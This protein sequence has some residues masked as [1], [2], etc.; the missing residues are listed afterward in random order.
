MPKDP[1]QTSKPG[2]M[3]DPNNIEYEEQVYLTRGL[4][5]KDVKNGV[6]LNLTEAKIIKN[7]FKSDVNFEE[8]FA[9]YYDGYADYIE[10]SINKLNELSSN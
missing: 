4:R 9:H 8:L 10:E 1:K 6:I 7:V 5:D 2:Y 3:K